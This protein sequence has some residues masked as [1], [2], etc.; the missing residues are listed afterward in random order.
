MSMRI[1]APIS[2]MLIAANIWAIAPAVDKEFDNAQAAN[3]LHQAV[4]DDNQADVDDDVIYEA[5]SKAKAAA[6]ANNFLKINR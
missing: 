5:S 2:A 4:N 1:I 3:L 6:H